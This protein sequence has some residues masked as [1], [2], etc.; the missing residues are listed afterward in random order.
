MD[1]DDRVTAPLHRFKNADHHYN[2]SSCKNFIKN[3][4]VPTL[5]INSLDNPSLDKNKFP[6]IAEVPKT[7]E[8]DFMKKE[9][10]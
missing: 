3:I 9:D 2:E 6:N 5:I 1:F 4:R 7:V 8:L 10:T